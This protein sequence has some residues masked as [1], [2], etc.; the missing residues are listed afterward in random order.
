[1]TPQERMLLAAGM[2][3]VSVV[4]KSLGLTPS[5]VLRRLESGAYRAERA[6]KFW[7]VQYADVLAAKSTSKTQAESLSNEVAKMLAKLGESK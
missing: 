5:A 3:R 1:M 6:G 7:Y 4:A 2:I